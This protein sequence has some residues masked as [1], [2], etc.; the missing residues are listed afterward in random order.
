MSH[1]HVKL[2]SAAKPMQCNLALE[3][4]L[5]ARV[6]SLG[7]CLGRKERERALGMTNDRPFDVVTLKGFLQ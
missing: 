5:Q 2:Q 6:G 3:H 1:L 4:S 7:T